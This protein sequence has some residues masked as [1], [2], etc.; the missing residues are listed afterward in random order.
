MDISWW[1]LSHFA[2]HGK[3]LYLSNFPSFFLHGDAHAPNFGNFWDGIRF[4]LVNLTTLNLAALG[5]FIAYFIQ[6]LESP[7][8]RDLPIQIEGRKGCIPRLMLMKML[9][10]VI[11]LNL[12]DRLENLELSLKNSQLSTS[13]LPVLL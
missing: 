3:K 5:R 4:L 7:R 9:D 11:R 1:K 6:R 12:H 8:L 10:T 13:I 2:R